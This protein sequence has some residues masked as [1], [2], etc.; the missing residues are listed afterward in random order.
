MLRKTKL[1]LFYWYYTSTLKF[2][3]FPETGNWYARYIK[4]VIIC[5]VENN[6]F[7]GNVIKWYKDAKSRFQHMAYFD[8][9]PPRSSLDKKTKRIPSL[10]RERL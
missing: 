4:D 10:Q 7:Y 3:K 2:V 1:L 9:M 5:K 8:I 6:S